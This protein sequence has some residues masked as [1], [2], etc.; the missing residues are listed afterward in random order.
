SIVGLLLFGLGPQLW[1]A[2]VGIVAWG[3]GAALGFP[4]GM[5]AAAD[6][7]RRAPARVAVVSTIGYSAFLAGPPLLGIL[8]E[9]VGYR[10]ALLAI[11]VPILIGLLVVNAARP[12]AGTTAL[13]TVRPTDT[14]RDPA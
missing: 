1:I 12:L 6:D 4:I 5:S 3:T 11:T 8:A 2:V 9:Q 10:Q 14:M 7:P 13:G